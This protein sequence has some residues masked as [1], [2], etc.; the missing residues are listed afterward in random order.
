MTSPCSSSARTPAQKSTSVK[1]ASRECLLLYRRARQARLL[2]V[3]RLARG[4]PRRCQ[5]RSSSVRRALGRSF[6]VRPP[7]R[8][9][10][11]EAVGRWLGRLVWRVS[12]RLG[13]GRETQ[14]EAWMPL[15]GAAQGSL[16]ACG[17]AAKGG[18]VV[19]RHGRTGRGG[20]PEGRRGGAATCPSSSQGPH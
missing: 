17:P 19:R 3:A 10:A 12:R 16:Q 4:G 14:R 7:H 5:C 20:H 1:T 9:P 6:G 8:W 11:R 2:A 18:R 13:W 15:Y